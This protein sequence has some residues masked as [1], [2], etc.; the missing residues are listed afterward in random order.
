MTK[1]CIISIFWACP[2]ICCG[3]LNSITTCYHLQVCN[4]CI[5]RYRCL[6]P[7]FYCIIMLS[8][9]TVIA[10]LKHVVFLISRSC[11]WFWQFNWPHWVWE[12]M[13][14]Q[15]QKIKMMQNLGIRCKSVSVYETNS[16]TNHT[17][18][19]ATWYFSEDRKD[20]PVRNIGVSHSRRSPLAHSVELG[21]LIWRTRVRAPTG[22]DD[23][24]ELCN[25]GI[26]DVRTNCIVSLMV[27]KSK[28]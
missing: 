17:N 25:I 21:N 6:I 1:F 12:Q 23:L 26:V 3:Q 10:F 2:I 27:I 22:A 9:S 15:A 16:S 5:A 4:T 11:N 8:Q 7:F 13:I 28:I 20:N 24:Y 19:P 18:V 14:G